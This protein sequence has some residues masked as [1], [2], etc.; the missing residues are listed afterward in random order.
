MG[1]EMCIRDSAAA[2]ARARRERDA[3]E[4]A[5]GIGSD[6]DGVEDVPR[7]A[8]A[9]R[10]MP[11]T[12]TPPIPPGAPSPA[13]TAGKLSN[14]PAQPACS[15]DQSAAQRASPAAPA[16][17]GARTPGSGAQEPP[18]RAA[19][20]QAAAKTAERVLTQQGATASRAAGAA[21]RPR[22][23]TDFERAWRALWRAGGP[24]QNA[25]ALRAYLEL[26]P[27]AEMAPLFGENLA[28]SALETLAVSARD[29]YLACGDAPRALALLC[30]LAR[31]RRFDVLW[32]FASKDAK[33]AARA[34]LSADE[35]PDAPFGPDDVSRARAAFL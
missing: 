3:A 26:I 18:K 24:A 4:N 7:P 15:A 28:D 1:S 13:P 11:A 21:V 12:P 30:G 5:R 20:L 8:P 29:L 31:V 34:V 35:P 33:A 19:N 32:M 10:A 6:D 9:K 25:D 23:A 17:A 2:K 14:P 16:P 22:S 27:P